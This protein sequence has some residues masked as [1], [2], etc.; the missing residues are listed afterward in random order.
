MFEM[1]KDDQ[2]GLHKKKKKIV[3]FFIVSLT[4]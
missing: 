3:L 4:R 1:S 2:K